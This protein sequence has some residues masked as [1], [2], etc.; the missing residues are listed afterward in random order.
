[1]QHA[2]HTNNWLQTI[3]ACKNMYA[4]EEQKFIAR[5]L[6]YLQKAIEIVYPTLEENYAQVFE[7]QIDGLIQKLPAQIGITKEHLGPFKKSVKGFEK[8]VHTSYGY[9]TPVPY[10][11]IGLLVGVV[12]GAVAGTFINYIIVSLIAGILM[13]LLLGSFLDK[14]QQKKGKLI[15]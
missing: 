8:Y 13:G 14:Q 4:P 3:N 1:M 15:V 12:I 2:T 9:K 5:E 6:H 10:Q 11:N 7:E